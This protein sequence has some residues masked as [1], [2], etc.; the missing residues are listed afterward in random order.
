MSAFMAAATAMNAQVKINVGNAE[1]ALDVSP[2]LYG[3]F[4]E[5]INHAADGGLYAELVSNR[6]F[7]DNEKVAE[8]WTATGG[9]QMRLTR[10]KLLNSAQKQA[11]EVTFTAMTDCPQGIA[12]SGFWGIN[13]VQGRTYKLSFWAKGKLSSN[14]AVSLTNANG[15]RVYDMEAIEGK[16][17]NKW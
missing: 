9:A 13:I 8:N 1:K 7:E 5:D 16:L 12:N 15:D 3:I 14:L 11:L 10:E 4:F 2:M 17:T 6:S